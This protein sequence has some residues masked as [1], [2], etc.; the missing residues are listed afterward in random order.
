M[1]G[2]PYDRLAN[3]IRTMTHQSQAERSNACVQFVIVLRDSCN[4]DESALIT[5]ALMVVAIVMVW[6]QIA[7]VLN[8]FGHSRFGHSHFG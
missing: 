2:S 7:D 4:P 1:V 3:R 6:G 5:F 8:Q